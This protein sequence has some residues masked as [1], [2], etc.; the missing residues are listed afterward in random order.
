M[1]KNLIFVIQTAFEKPRQ[2][3]QNTGSLAGAH[4]DEM[5]NNDSY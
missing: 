1:Y 3:Q 5:S 2:S 4:G